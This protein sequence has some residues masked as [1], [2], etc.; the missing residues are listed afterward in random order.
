MVIR[1]MCGVPTS[2]AGPPVLTV[3]EGTLRH[4]TPEEGQRLL[5]RPLSDD[6]LEP[7]LST[8]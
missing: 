2:P 6:G 3:V 7:V 8:P 5:G 1:E 4:D